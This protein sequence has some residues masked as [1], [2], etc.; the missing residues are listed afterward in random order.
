MVGL[1]FLNFF[2]CY[3]KDQVALQ[4]RLQKETG[5][6]ATRTFTLKYVV[7]SWLFGA[8]V[9]LKCVITVTRINV[10]ITRDSVC[11]MRNSIMKFICRFSLSL[12][13]CVIIALNENTRF[14]MR[15]LMD[16]RNK[17]YLPKG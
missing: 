3:E 14:R 12:N 6:H 2:H 17:V 10:I 8:V 11:L 15:Q 9:L 7:T 13:Y 5:S 4:L 16:E 1:A